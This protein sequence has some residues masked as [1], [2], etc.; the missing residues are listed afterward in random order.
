MANPNPG[1][2]NLVSWWEFNESSGNA[3]DDVGTNT[4]TNNGTIAYTAGLRGN[5]ADLGTANTTKYFNKAS[6][7]GLSVNASR[8]Y[9][10]FIKIRTELSGAD[11]YLYPMHFNHSANGVQYYIQYQ[12]ESDT[13]KIA[14]GRGRTLVADDGVKYNVNLG[15]TSWHLIIVTWDGTTNILYLDGASVN[16]GNPST[17]NGTALGS[18]NFTVGRCATASSGFM[19]MYAD[20][21][22]V[23]NTAL[24]ADNV[25]WLWAAGM[26]RTYSD[27]LGISTPSVYLSDYGV[28]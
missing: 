8:S 1:I 20:E 6:V 23:F 24:T 10:T 16:S 11:Q 7:L 5:C 13:N 17:A 9:G 19:N 15:T 12:R 18:D 25:S 3:I 2:A 27:L 22:F 14:G 4:L 21:S 28:M 26:G